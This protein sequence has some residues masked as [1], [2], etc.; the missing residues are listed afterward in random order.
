MTD[1]S[2]IVRPL[3]WRELVL[4]ASDGDHVYR[5]KAAKTPFGVLRIIDHRPFMGADAGFSFSYSAHV[6]KLMGLKDEAEAIDAAQADYARRILS[7]IDPDAII[8]AGV[9]EGLR[10]GAE[11]AEHRWR[12]WGNLAPHEKVECDVTACE[13]VARSILSTSPEAIAAA[14]ERVKGGE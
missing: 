14:V 6:E 8:A 5:A 2:K 3:E 4:H 11:A 12:E 7:A 13:D 9:R 1:L 10:M